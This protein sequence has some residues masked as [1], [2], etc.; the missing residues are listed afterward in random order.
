MS[1]GATVTHQLQGRGLHPGPLALPSP[2]GSEVASSSVA[3]MLIM[4]VGSHRL[5]GTS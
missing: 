4:L 5:L 1:G 2:L 3:S